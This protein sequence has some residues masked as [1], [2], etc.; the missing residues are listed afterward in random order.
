MRETLRTYA[1][2]GLG[3]AEVA[4]TRA[5]TLLR[6]TLEHAPGVTPSGGA[7]TTPHA[8]AA[9]VDAPGAG[10][11]DGES[12]RREVDLAIGR[13]GLVREEEIAALRRHVRRLEESITSLLARE[14]GQTSPAA[15]QAVATAPVATAPVATQVATPQP[16][17]L[18]KAPA[19]E[20]PA[21]EVPAGEH[22]A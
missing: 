10:V 22:D 1:Q 14:A 5:A 17:P 3:F 20:A 7:T 21:D 8:S 13:L 6:D 2:L 4:L 15:T 11:D 12:I 18:R 16:G 19:D 9:E